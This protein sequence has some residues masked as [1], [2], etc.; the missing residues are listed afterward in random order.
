[1]SFGRLVTAMITPF[2]N[3]LEVNLKKLVELTNHLVDTGT[4][5]I[6]IAGTTG[7]TPTLSHDEEFSMFELALKSVK[8]RAKVMAGTG[9]NSTKTAVQSTI[10]AARLGVDSVLQVVPYYNK[11]SQEG[12]YRHFKA[13]AEATTLPIMLY[14]IPGRTGINMEPETVARLVKEC[15]TIKAIKEA[16]NSVD[17][18]KKIRS[19]TP[20]SFLIYSGDDSNTLNF[21]EAGAFGVVSVASH[22]AGNMITEMMNLFAAGNK[23]EARVLEE[24]LMPLFN[25]LFITSNPVPVKAALNM[26]GMDV[27]GVRL[28][29]VEANDEQKEFVKKILKD[30]NLL[31]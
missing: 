25:G 16:A 26:M 8:G 6:L 11:P 10:E 5:T 19:L 29:L 2:D 22:C 14:N 9:S 7:E 30:L 17:Q 21:M 3:H 1:M 4:E 23:A 27:G 31:K 15:P 20:E 18:V 12:L 13:V 24:K 28:P